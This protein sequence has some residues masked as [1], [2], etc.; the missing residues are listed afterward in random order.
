[1]LTDLFQPMHLLVI[2]VVILCVSPVLNLLWVPPLWRIFRK[3]GVAPAYSLLV[4]L[5]IINLVT[6]YAIVFFKRAAFFAPAA[7]APEN[8]PSETKRSQIV[9]H[10]VKKARGSQEHRYLASEG[11]RRLSLALAVLAAVWG[12]FV[13][14]ANANDAP[15]QGSP[16]VLVMG[17]LFISAIIGGAVWCFVRLIDWTVAGFRIRSTMQ[18]GDQ[19]MSKYDPLYKHLSSL[20]EQ[21]ATMTFVEIE[22]VLGFPLP[23]SAREYAAWWANANPASGQHPY[24]LAWLR[25]GRK[26]TVNLETERVVFERSN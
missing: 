2:L 6:M 26:A 15:R 12:F 25:S 10:L 16:L 11:V 3:A 20:T 7:G 21:S 4:V 14:G 1:M 24:S 8:F 5:P 19:K 9:R 22:R 13:V 18:D 17:L 23:P